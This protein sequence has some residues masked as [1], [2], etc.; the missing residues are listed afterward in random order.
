MNI[1]TILLFLAV[2][3]SSACATTKQPITNEQLMQEIK[4]IRE[5]NLVLRAEIEAQ[6]TTVDSRQST[7]DSRE[8]FAQFPQPLPEI[9]PAQ[10]ILPGPPQNWAWPHTPPN[11]C[12]AGPFRLQINN[13]F[14]DYYVRM[15]ID[16]EEVVTRSTP[17]PGPDG[18][19][20]TPIPPRGAQ[21][22]GANPVR[23]FACLNHLGAHTLSGVIYA[24][25]MGILVEIKRFS[26]NVDYNAS[27]SSG[28]VFDL[29]SNLL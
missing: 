17:F 27:A 10:P 8:E 12:E 11:G 22:F 5:E 9:P 3:L 29:M 13:W 26:E 15:F 16:G 14:P 25:R 28:Q 4:G 23:T 19:M 21:R 6:K 20:M 24:N 7:V 18:T 1:Q 2:A